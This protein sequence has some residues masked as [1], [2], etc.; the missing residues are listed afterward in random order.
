MDEPLRQLLDAMPE[1]APR[2]KL[3]PY[4][5]VIRELRRKRRTYEQIA[6]FL[7]EQFHVTA[8]RTT[9][10]AF[11]AVRARRKIK[12]VYELPAREAD[13]EQTPDRSAPDPTDPIEALRQRR[14]RRAEDAPSTTP[15]AKN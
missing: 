9:I 13:K 12:T 3:E 2:S 4:C 5:D 6:R 11:V 10:H 7:S 1:T 15:R 14:P 8:A